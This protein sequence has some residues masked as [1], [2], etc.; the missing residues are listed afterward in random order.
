M[1][2]TT[3]L[4]FAAVTKIRL[5][6]LLPADET[7]R[8]LQRGPYLSFGERR[9]LSFVWGSRVFVRYVVSLLYFRSLHVSGEDIN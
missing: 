5:T 6:K 8:R 4:R 9:S 1:Y 7:L 3:V 2:A